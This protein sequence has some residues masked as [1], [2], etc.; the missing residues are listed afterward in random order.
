MKETKLPLD[1]LAGMVVFAQVVD[2]GGFSAAARVIGVSKSAVSKQVSALED[3][4]GARLLQRTTRQMSLTEVGSAFL[5]RCRRVL[6][7]AEEAEAAVTALQAAP[8]GVLRINGPMTFGTLHL[9]AAIPEFMARHPGLVVDLTLNDRFVDLVE[10]GYDMALRIGRLPDSSLVARRIAPAR[11]VLVASPAYIASRGAPHSLADIAAHDC[12][13]YAYL[14]TGD[15]W[16]FDGPAGEESV[17][18]SGRLRAN[19]GEVLLEAARAGTGIAALPTFIVGPDL[20]AGRLVRVLPA[21]DNCSSSI[22]AVWPQG[23]HLSLKVRAFVDFLLERFGPV[24][25]WEPEP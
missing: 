23:K 19:N 11:R 16:R 20:K 8:R 17:K 9:A 6:A 2:A 3:R 24:P 22:S 1:I 4:L 10:E 13:C 15:E 14:A 5:E 12:L 18:V 7:E 21:H 25:Y